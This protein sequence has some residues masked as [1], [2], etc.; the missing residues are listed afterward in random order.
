MD[1]IFSN[2]RLV[3]EE[4]SATKEKTIW[5][6]CCMDGI[7]MPSRRLSPKDS[8]FIGEGP[9]NRT[10]ELWA[11]R[12]AY[13]NEMKKN[14]RVQNFYIRKDRDGNPLIRCRIDGVQQLSSQIT[15]TEADMYR[16]GQ[17]TERELVQRYY[18]H[19]LEL[20]L[21]QNVEDSVSRN[22][23]RSISQKMT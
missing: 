17:M 9:Y 1:E 2:I 20:E 13:R 16:R 21:G 6:H 12:M 4:N 10:Q 14:Q 18:T 11:A 15:R 8:H 7:D 5:V 22:L 23:T 19:A 3:P